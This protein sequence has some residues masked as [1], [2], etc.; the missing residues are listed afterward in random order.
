[1]GERP[2]ISVI[3]PIY[4]G[5]KYIDRCVGSLLQ[6]TIKEIE[7]ILIDDG[8][9]D[10]SF[11]KC[12]KWK[13]KD[14]R[15]ICIHQKNAGVSAAR[16]RGIQEA[17]GKYIGF[18]D[19]DDWID[20]DMYEIL[21][22]NII[23]TKATISFISLIVHKDGKKIPVYGTNNFYVWDNMEIPLEYL[24]EEKVFCYAP[25]AQLI[26]SGYC[27]KYKFIEGRKLNEDKFFAFNVIK[28][29]ERICCQDICKYHYV[30]HENSAS[31]SCFG[32]KF[33]DCTYFAEEMLECIRLERPQL[34]E[35][36]EHNLN[37]T[38]IMVLKYMCKSKGGYKKYNKQ[39]LS[40]RT[41][42]KDYE[43]KQNKHPRGMIRKIELNLLLDFPQIYYFIWIL[44]NFMKR[45]KKYD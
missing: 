18:C 43:K 9:S 31:T 33:F 36:A 32:N 37:N 20:L 4:N 42:I 22:K 29:A 24:F 2:L 38:K 28:D 26:E 25:Y 39:Y 3:V 1:M 5:E 6:Q 34:I 45:R 13:D 35:E 27:K 23:K 21:Y 14:S 44:I 19:I 12:L 15:I 41:D 7:I 30:V 11:Q 17:T 10:D 16:N 40:L 8:S